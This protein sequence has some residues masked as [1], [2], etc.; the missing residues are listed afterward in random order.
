MRRISLRHVIT[1]A[2]DPGP[3]DGGGAGGVPRGVRRGVARRAS[4]GV[5]SPGAPHLLR[6]ALRARG[7]RRPPAGAA[8]AAHRRALMSAPDLIS[9]IGDCRIKLNTTVVLIASDCQSLFLDAEK[10]EAGS[11]PYQ[12]P[13]ADYLSPWSGGIVRQ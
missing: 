13:E 1:G 9:G 12:T 6:P 4:R 10:R 11:S 2:G 7:S 8:A 5:P 3:P